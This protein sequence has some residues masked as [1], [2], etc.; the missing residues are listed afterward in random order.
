M[1]GK[2]KKSMKK[3]MHVKHEDGHKHGGKV[4]KGKKMHEHKVHGE[5]SKHRLDKKMRGKAS[6]GEVG[7]N[8]HPLSTANKISERPGF[9]E[10]KLDKEMD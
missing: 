5:K 1:K 9:G 8:D 10:N 3:A 2:I 7:S 6:G 4:H